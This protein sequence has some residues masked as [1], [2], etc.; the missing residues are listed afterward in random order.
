MRCP[1]CKAEN[2]VG[3]S[4]RRCKA[5]LGLLFTLQARRREFLDAARGNLAAGNWPA[6]AHAAESA[7]RLQND[8]ESRQLVAVAQLFGRDFAAAWEWYCRAKDA[9]G[10]AASNGRP[11]GISD[12]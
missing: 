7:D 5:D 1:V 11:T 9:G 3:P 8:D 12:A 2:S 4:C 6:A 10:S